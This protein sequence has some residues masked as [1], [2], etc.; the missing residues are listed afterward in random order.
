MAN[1]PVK[2]AENRLARFNRERDTLCDEVVRRV[3]DRRLRAAARG[4]DH[5]LE[6]VL[7]DAAYHEI[8][9]LE[10]GS[11]GA[12]E[13][14]R[15]PEW[16]ELARGL[17]TMPDEDKRQ[18]LG[19]LVREYADDVAG[20]F[21][22]R[23]YRFAKGVLPAVLAGV[24]APGRLKEGLQAVGDL[25]GKVVVDGPIDHLRAVADRGTLVVTPT[26]SSNM[27]SVVIGFAFDQAGLPPVTYGAGKNLFSN[28]FISFFMHNLG[29]YRVDRRLRHEI[30][31][32]VLKEYSTV[33]LEHG[34]HS[35]FFPGGT[36]SRSGGVERRLKLGLLGTAMQAYQNHLAAG[37]PQKRIYVVPATI[38]YAITLEAE[39]LIDDF[40]AEEGKHRYIIEDDEFSS[41]ARLYDFAKHVMSREGHVHIRFGAPLDPVGNTV[42]EAG[43]SLDPR[44]RRVDPASY[45]LGAGGA[46]AADAQRDAEYTKGLGEELVHQYAR[47]S[48]LMPTHLTAR[49][50][51]DSIAARQGTRDVYRLLRL[52]GELAAPLDQVRR[53]V[54]AWRRR[55]VERPG[56]GALAPIAARIDPGALVDEAIT[57]WTA[58]HQRPAAAR[59]GEQ[60]VVKDLRLILY[61]Q[62]R[63]AHLR[64]A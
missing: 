64:G 37:A 8:R 14:K 40:L 39:T 55:I 22:E 34:F 2:E 42:D 61:Y 13:K 47:L 4:G 9:R 59:A 24:I 33:L 41:L 44:G 35:L 63:M 21:D 30:Y 26:H 56:E 32:D 11:A 16:R 17:G 38:N 36:R 20:R 58:Y 7:N 29:A 5:S 28:R 12:G 10:S 1:R 3:M 57:S 51:M 18:R 43:E 31:K 50:L 46:L 60:V 52:Q 25:Q 54:D 45:F 27:D 6:Y 62:N 15:L 53:D 23:V 19:A 48:V 49:V